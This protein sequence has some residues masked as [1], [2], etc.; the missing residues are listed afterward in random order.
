[1]WLTLVFGVMG[2]AELYAVRT[3]IG[4]FRRLF[5]G[6]A[7]S[8]AR[9]WAKFSSAAAIPFRAANVRGLQD[10]PAGGTPDGSSLVVQRGVCST[11]L[12]A[13]AVDE[14]PRGSGT[15][16]VAEILPMPGMDL[17]HEEAVTMEAD[18]LT[19]IGMRA[20]AHG[21]RVAR[22]S[23]VGQYFFV[24]E[25]DHD[26]DAIVG[27]GPEYLWAPAISADGLVFH[28][29]V[30]GDPDP[31]ANGIYESVRAATGVPFPP[32]RRM[33]AVVQAYGQYVNGLSPDRL[34]IFLALKDGVDGGFATVLLSRA[35]E[36]EPFANP[37]APDPPPR[38]PGLRTR[39]LAGWNSLIGSCAP[40]GGG[41]RGED[42]CTWP[43]GAAQK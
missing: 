11:D 33:P 38:V 43:A 41:C 39:P 17:T 4:G 31:N 9:A 12:V 23:A 15:Y 34:T 36:T 25:D 10:I 16:R 40:L 28:Y 27:S 37:N 14:V 20:D 1:M 30:A 2:A 32:G 22:R 29:T 7:P 35:N 3:G 24:A 19:I 6:P 5:G 18:G 21:F 26:L 8:P 42:V 13:L